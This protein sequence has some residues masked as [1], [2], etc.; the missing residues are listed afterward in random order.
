VAGQKWPAS[1]ELATPA[2]EHR[3][4]QL[5]LIEKLKGVHKKIKMTNSLILFTL[6]VCQHQK[7]EKR[8]FRAIVHNPTVSAD[9]II[10]FFSAAGF[11]LL[12]SLVIFLLT[13]NTIIL[14]VVAQLNQVELKTV[15]VNNRL[16]C[17]VCIILVAD[18]DSHNYL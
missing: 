18:A 9:R 13:R 14:S 8:W 3:V 5:G 16:P 6:G 11:F 17:I 12:K 4:S 10:S 1:S 7:L 15:T 2:R